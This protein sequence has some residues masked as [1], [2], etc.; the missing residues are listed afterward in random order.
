M[1]ILMHL[2]NCPEIS[3]PDQSDVDGDTVG[4]DCDNCPEIS[5]PFQSDVDG[6]TVGDDCAVFDLTL[7][8]FMQIIAQIL[9]IPTKKIAIIMASAIYVIHVM[10]A[11][12]QILTPSQILVII[13]QMIRMLSRWIVIMM[14]LVMHVI[15]VRIYQT[16]TKAILM[17]ILW[18]M[19][20][21]IAQILPIPT[22]KIAI[23]MASAI[24]VVR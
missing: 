7:L 8:H 12:T 23:I 2:D 10:M 3:N 5:N 14:A 1:C 20:A 19:I 24:Y 18:E 6:D 15:I 4:D 17:M 9:P 21:I 11:Q 16:Q 22:K 13:A